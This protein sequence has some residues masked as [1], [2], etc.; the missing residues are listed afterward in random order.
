ME[1]L[2]RIALTVKTKSAALH[3]ET[4]VASHA[5]TGSDVGEFGHSRKQFQVIHVY[6][7]SKHQ[8]M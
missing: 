3:F 7:N 4:M 8:L 6:I 2:V 1:N 5:F